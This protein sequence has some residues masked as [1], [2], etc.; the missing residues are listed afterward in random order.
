MKL[1]YCRSCGN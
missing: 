1:A